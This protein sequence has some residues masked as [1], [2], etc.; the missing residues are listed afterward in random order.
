M[1]GSI[2]SRLL[3]PVLLIVCATARA[4][5]AAELLASI[6][7]RA[8]SGDLSAQEYLGFAFRNG[9]GTPRD[10]GRALEWFQRAAAQGSTRA[11]NELGAI[12][13]TRRDLAT[14]YDWYRRSAEAKDPQGMFR[15]GVMHHRGWHVKR[16]LDAAHRFIAAAAERG[17]MEAA[18]FL[19][20]MYYMGDQVARDP[21]RAYVWLHV[22]A[23]R[24]PRY[25]RD[26]Q[27]VAKEL[28]PAQL[29][30]AQLKAD[31]WMRRHPAP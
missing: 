7:E 20:M 2:A 30:E 17:N 28:T 16:D 19:G 12:H 25:A 6:G 11:M 23:A 21:Q 9:L 22:A 18:Q 3:G 31:D 29:R 13:T 1:R 10:E 14:A 15:V 4:D 27:A 24:E 8:N 5:V 26:R